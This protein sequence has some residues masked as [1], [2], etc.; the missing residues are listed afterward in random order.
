MQAT[1]RGVGID[2]AGSTLDLNDNLLAPLSVK[3]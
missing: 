1:A 2:L 3:R